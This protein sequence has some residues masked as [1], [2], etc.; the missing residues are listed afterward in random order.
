M[1]V[2]MP[3]FNEE[4]A[5]GPTVEALRDWLRAQGRPYEL[6]V[7]DNASQDATLA[8]LEQHLVEGDLR[9][10]RNE[11][12]RG[13]GFSV[14]RGMLEASGEVRLLCDADCTSS[15]VSLPDMLQAL[16]GADMVL[17]SRVAPGAQVDRHQP[18]RR[19]A[20]SLPFLLLTRAVMRE[21]SKD[22]FC[23]F[24]LWRGPAAEAIFA[25]QSVDGWAFD[26]ECIALA[27]QLGLRVSEVG[28]RWTNRPGSKLVIGRTLVPALRELLAARRNVKRQHGQRPPAVALSRE[29]AAKSR[30]E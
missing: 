24:K 18:L 14:R 4:E 16:E 17:G 2:V 9:V 1:S 11:T 10:L 7:V 28:I 5:V 30:P 26:T 12:N 3:V 22:I 6:I 8:R 29:Q 13:K 19:R 27:R 23:G 15:L 21:R 20:F 25:R